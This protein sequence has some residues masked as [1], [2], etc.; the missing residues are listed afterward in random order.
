MA[1]LLDDIDKRT[2]KLVDDIDKRM[3]ELDGASD[4]KLDARLAELDA[5]IKKSGVKSIFPTRA[6]APAPAP[7][8]ASKPAGAPATAAAR[9]PRWGEPGFVTGAQFASGTTPE[10]EKRHAKLNKEF[11]RI[12]KDYAD[13]GFLGATPIKALQRREL[14]KALV[15]NLDASQAVREEEERNAAWQNEQMAM[16]AQGLPGPPEPERVAKWLADWRP[17]PTIPYKKFFD[18]SS[19]SAASST[20]TPKA[21]PEVSPEAPQPKKD[22]G[23]TG[24]KPKESQEALEA[25]FTRP[26]EDSPAEAT[27]PPRLFFAP[28]PPLIKD[29][30]GT[31]PDADGFTPVFPATPGKRPPVD[32]DAVRKQAKI[33]QEYNEAGFKGLGELE[34]MKA[35]K[36]AQAPIGSNDG[37]KPTASF[38]NRMNRKALSAARRADKY[39]YNSLAAR[40]FEAVANDFDTEEDFLAELQ[41]EDNPWFDMQFK[42]LRDTRSFLNEQL[43]KDAEEEERQRQAREEAENK[44]DK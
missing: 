27:T 5:E 20:P 14:E 26:R 2:K 9:K 29:P 31:A 28:T 22:P 35:S 39:G 34:M 23:T 44:R 30:K 32:R 17:T 36:E 21:P 1:S 4:E 18:G 12:K 33:A 40:E 3:K 8:A 42:D 7:A 6:P 37:A 13:L 38:A 19:K 24:S 11:S 15:Y 16:T 25:T 41:K 10:T 43:R